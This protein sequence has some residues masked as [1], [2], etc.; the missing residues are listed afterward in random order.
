MEIA[1]ILVVQEDAGAER[2]TRIVVRDRPVAFEFRSPGGIAG[3]KTDLSG[4]SAVA[5][6]I[7]CASPEVL[8]AL[9]GEG[10]G[11][12]PLFFFRGEPPLQ[13]VARWV[14]WSDASNGGEGTEE[15]RL[16][17]ESLE[18][19]ALASLYQ[20][21]IRILTSQDEEKLLALITD[22]FVRELGAESCV[23]WLASPSDPDEMMIASVRGVVNIDRE[24]S[25]FFLSQADW[26]G[27]GP[28]PSAT[29]AV[30]LVFHERTIGMVKLGER[31]N[32]KPYGE[33]ERYVSGILSD[34][35][36]ISLRT[37]DRLGRMGKASLHDPETRAYS[38]AF[39]SDY[40]EKERYKAGRFRRPLS[41]IFVAI[42]NFAHL[43]EQTRESMVTG[44]LVGMVEAIRK[45]LR[46]SDL[47]ARTGPDRFCI[48]LPETDYFG[49]VLALRR[50]RKAVS[51][52]MRIPFLGGE[53]ALHPFFM[54]VTYPRDGMDFQ[55]LSQLAEEKYVRQRKSPLH[56]LRLMEKSFWDAFDVLVGKPEHYAQLRRGEDVP[57]FGRI[58]KDLGRNGHFSLPR[59][60]YLRLVESVAQDVA[61]EGDAR[62]LVIAAGPRPEIFKQI[63]LSFGTEPSEGRSICILGQAGNTRFDAKHLLY[64]SAD[65]DRL[66]ER[67]V[68]LYLKENGAYG[69]FSIGPQED[70][71][72]FHTADEWLVE[73]MMEKFQ[74]TYLLQGTI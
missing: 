24:G 8:E 48:V 52:I 16:L 50:L 72:G 61:S 27:T 43:M 20:R 62:A 54:S 57:S 11:G 42:D 70:A 55:A 12:P 69:L 19:Y 29:L 1:R 34:Y 5:A 68:V 65:D 30:P 2:D 51:E 74:D 33:H 66:K 58:R 60:I 37:V 40:F 6:P 32:R 9:R 15:E 46:D 31:S 56:R 26:T 7:E 3:G 71:C 18:Y 47:I 63:F 44:A 25:R 53:F 45:A 49:S 39:L 22:A 67:E 64:R 36:A 73:S 10:G 21:C 4:F 28:E 14:L 13:E 41:L 38:A 17:S 23:I 35:A 59:E